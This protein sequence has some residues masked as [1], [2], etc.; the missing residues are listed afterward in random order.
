MVLTHVAKVV[1]ISAER[2]DWVALSLREAVNNAVLHGNKKD[3]KKWIEVT[4]EQAGDEFIM[5]ILDEGTGFD[6]SSLSDPRSPENLF[7]PNGRGIF[8]IRQF[9]DRVSFIQSEDGRF[10][11][12]IAVK[13]TGL[14]SQE[15]G[16]EPA[17]L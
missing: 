9:S 10:G 1:G 4:M 11:V 17:S 6:T 2:L 15:A 8:L 7:R 5:R 3:P 16:N 14:E 12:E 13:L